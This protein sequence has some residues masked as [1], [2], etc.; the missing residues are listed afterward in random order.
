MARNIVIC[1]DGTGNRYGQKNTNVVKLFQIL[2]KHPKRQ[3]AFYDPG[4]GT[5]GS[6]FSLTFIGR[7]L[8]KLMGLVTAYGMTKNIE[9]AYAYLMEKYEE[10]DKVFLFGFSRGAFTVRALA[11]MLHKCGL[12]EKGCNNL[13]PYASNMYRKGSTNVAKG[14]KRTFCRE[15]RPHF[16]GVWDTVKSV[17]LFFPRKFPNATLNED[18][19]IGRHA[20]AIDEKRSKFKANLWDPPAPH[21][22][23]QQ[24]WFSGMHSD[25]GGSYPE[26]GLSNIALRWMI[27][28]AE[29]EGLL[30][31]QDQKKVFVPNHRD[32]LHN[33]LLPFWWILGW[34]IRK[35]RSGSLVHISVKRRMED[36]KKYR[37]K[38]LPED[39]IWHE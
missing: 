2:I 19:S 33:S 36:K 17:G 37:P 34:W 26:T 39:P 24:V 15:C 14:F 8:T 23:I 31:D 4:V 35:I 9:D 16:I 22:D 21:Q 27:H 13:I 12:L 28:E 10:G 29:N 7:A 30:V 11:G 3:P 5:L 32:K 18:V 38:N 20:L 25:I 6:H 1:C